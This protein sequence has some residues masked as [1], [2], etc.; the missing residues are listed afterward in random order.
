MR[1]Y[2]AFRIC[3]QEPACWI[4]A[5]IILI[6]AILCILVYFKIVRWWFCNPALNFITVYSLSEINIST[7]THSSCGLQHTLSF[8][9]LILYYLNTLKS[10]FPLQVFLSLPSLFQ[11]VGLKSFCHCYGPGM[12]GKDVLWYILLYQLYSGES[13]WQGFLGSSVLPQV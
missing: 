10:P 4:R 11:Q 12:G 9:T 8:W 6:I 2:I 3:Q 1:L 5:L 13:C 7:R